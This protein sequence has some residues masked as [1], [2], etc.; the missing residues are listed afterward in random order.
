MLR[1]CTCKLTFELQM[2]W[3]NST[4][5]SLFCRQLMLN[6]YGSITDKIFFTAEIYVVTSPDSL[7][8]V[9]LRFWVRLVCDVFCVNRAVQKLPLIYRVTPIFPFESQALVIPG[10]CDPLMVAPSCLNSTLVQQMYGVIF[11]HLL[12]RSQLIYGAKLWHISPAS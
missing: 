2:G 5:V 3:M 8:P 7:I 10:Y 11:C 1:H 9:C 12:F 6:F 4:S